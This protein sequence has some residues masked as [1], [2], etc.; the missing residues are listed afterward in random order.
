[1]EEAL[2]EAAFPADGV[3][4]G[5]GVASVLHAVEW[6]DGLLRLVERVVLGDAS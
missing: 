2:M 3:E 4:V 5:E 1:M 6:R